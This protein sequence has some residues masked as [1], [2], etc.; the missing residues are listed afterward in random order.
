VAYGYL[1]KQATT[2]IYKETEIFISAA[3]ATRTYVKDVLRPK[4]GPLIPPELFIPHAM[5]TSFVGREIM[6]RLKQRFPEFFI[7]ERP[8]TPPT[9]STRRM[10]LNSRCSTGLTK[11]RT[12][13]N[14]MV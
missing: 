8:P 14:G 3:D 4:V 11:T 9:R 5:S 1:K 10:R 2:E 6:N 13:V 12:P 7:S